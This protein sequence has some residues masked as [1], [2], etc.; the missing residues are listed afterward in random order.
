MKC[1]RGL[2]MRILS[3]R[4]V[5]PSVKRVHCKI[6]GSGILKSTDVQSRKM[7]KVNGQRSGSQR[8]VMYQQQKRHKDQITL[9]Q[10]PRRRS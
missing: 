10:F 5:R 3:V 8:K 4:P 6:F 9:G 7:L 1:R 2:A